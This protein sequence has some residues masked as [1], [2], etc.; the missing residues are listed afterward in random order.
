MKSIGR[1]W[2]VVALCILGASRPV[3]AQSDEERASARAAA[4]QG[5]AALK[6]GRYAE[7]ADLLVRAESVV[8]APTHLLYLARAQTKL[9]KIVKARET[10]L[11]LE[12]EEIPVNAP[13][14][15]R[16]AKMAA[17]KERAEI[18]PQL[19]YVTV[20]VEGPG[21]ANARVLVDGAEVPRPLVGIAQP[22][23]P[24]PHKYQA[25]GE[26]AESAVVTLTLAQGA[27]QTVPLVLRATSQAPAST[28]A[29]TRANESPS[30]APRA[31]PPSSPVEPARVE[32]SSGGGPS[33][34]RVLSY[35]SLGIGAIGLGAGGAFLVRAS[36]RDKESSELYE[37]CWPRGC[38]TQ[39]Q[40]Q[41]HDLDGQ[42]NSARTTATV[43]FAVGGVGV[44]AGVL[45]LILDAT[46]SPAKTA[47]RLRPWVGLD[48]AGVSGSF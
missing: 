27:R 2:T 44:A 47:S 25:V 35:V 14:P 28:S 6:E 3:G 48:M 33:A 8:H 15:F 11:K 32:V 7:A 39:E 43:A 12:R 31:A 9:G 29:A 23:D 1:R 24:G 19:A 41:V 20:A 36:G 21:Q 5:I 40:S 46:G 16:D 17:A 18:E 38:S 30:A 42:A 4:Q 34:L 26:G 13:K 22:T 10:Y 37:Q 45:M